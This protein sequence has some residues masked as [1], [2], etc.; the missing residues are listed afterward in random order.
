MIIVWI[1]FG[2]QEVVRVSFS[3][4]S[5]VLIGAYFHTI[6]IISYSASEICGNFFIVILQILQ[7]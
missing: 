4:I 1:V 2:L 6:F 7:M 3:V 5:F